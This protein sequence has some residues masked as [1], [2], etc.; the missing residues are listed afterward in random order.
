MPGKVFVSYSKQD[1]TL[2]NRIVQ[3]L[4][5]LTCEGLEV[6]SDEDIPPGDDW[7][8][9]IEAAMA[10]CQ[11]ALL[12]ISPDFLTTGFIL[13]KEVPELLARRQ[14][15]GLCIIP[16]ILSPC[17]WQQVGWLS[18][19][20]VRPL[21]TAIPAAAQTTAAAAPVTVP[22]TRGASSAAGAPLSSPATE[23]STTGSTTPDVTTPD[24]TTPETTTPE[25]TA[26]SGT[27]T[28]PAAG[29]G[30]G[31]GGTTEA[32]P[33]EAAPPASPPAS[34]PAA[35]SP[36]NTSPGKSTTASPNAGTNGKPNTNGQPANPG[37]PKSN[38]PPKSD[39]ATT[40]Q[41]TSTAPDVVTD[42]PASSSVQTVP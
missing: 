4:K 28:A 27:A 39:K 20:N 15:D 3:H 12:L 25:T 35:P 7:L 34:P 26:P 32:P 37:Q 14:A 21:V 2:K 31:T 36:Q 8:P 6:W 40:S 19:I 41:G 42:A 16:V 30:T 13:G 24:A 22:A 29:S 33:T 9:A 10:D 23:T 18:P 38:T 17:A 1:E 11:V 5:V